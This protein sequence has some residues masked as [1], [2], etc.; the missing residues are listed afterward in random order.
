[1]N[2][3]KP[4][5]MHL[6]PPAK[7]TCPA[8]AVNHDPTYPH[9]CDSLYYQMRF[10]GLRGRWPTWGDALAHCS[11]EMKAMWEEGLKAEGHWTEPEGEPIADPPEESV[12]Q[13]VDMET[14]Q[15]DAE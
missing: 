12:S 15:K 7:G 9:N 5:S 10:H 13:V 14:F 6:M 8:C 4:R 2:E 11:K 1:M 3:L